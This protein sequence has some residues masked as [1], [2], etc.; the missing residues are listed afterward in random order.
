MSSTPHPD[1]RHLAAYATGN[2]AVDEAYSIAEHLGSCSEC[3]ATIQSL[4]AK[5]DTLVNALQTKPAAEPYDDEAELR[6]AVAKAAQ[7]SSLR[8]NE[9]AAAPAN[10]T[11]AQAATKTPPKLGPYQLLAK[12]GEGGMGAVFKARHEHLDKIV[13][14]KVLSKKALQDSAAVARFRRE[15]KAVGAL[16]HPNIVGAHDAGEQQGVHFLVMEYVAGRD[17]STLVKQNGPVTVAQAISYMQQAAKG[18]AFAH[19][20]NIV[21]RDIKPANLLVDGE[22]TIKILDLGLARL[23]DGGATGAAANVEANQGLT[24]TGQVMGTVDYMA[25][26]QAFDTHRA[27]AKADVYSLGC[28]LFRIL[29]GKNAYGGDTV[30]Q[31]ILAHREHPIPSLIERRPE[32]PAALDAIYR[33]MMTKQPEQRPTMAELCMEF[34]ALANPA[35]AQSGPM[36]VIDTAKK[37]VGVK[38]Q[39]SATNQL[40]AEPRTKRHANSAGGGRGF[41]PPKKLIAACGGFAILFAGVIFTIRD[42]DGNKV[43]EVHAPDGSSVEA[44]PSSKPAGAIRPAITLAPVAGAGAPL[45]PGDYA[46]RFSHGASV[47]V[48]SLAEALDPAGPLTVECWLTPGYYLYGQ[49]EQLGSTLVKY[50][51]EVPY[52]GFGGAPF[53]TAIN[54]SGNFDF[55]LYANELLT[56]EGDEGKPP[57]VLAAQGQ[58]GAN[59]IYIGGGG[60]SVAKQRPIHLACVRSRNKAQFYVAGK[61]HHFKDLPPITLAKAKQPFTI[62]GKDGNADRYFHGVINEVRVSKTVRYDKDFTPPTRFEPDPETTALYHFDEATGDV[63]HDASANKHDGKIVGAKWVRADGSEIPPPSAPAATPTG[64]AGTIAPI[65]PASPIPAA[66]SSTGYALSFGEG[67]TVEIP[68]LNDAFDPTGPLTVE[69]WI[70]PRFYNAQKKQ[71]DSPLTQFRGAVPIMAFYLQTEDYVKESGH[72]TGTQYELIPKFENGAHKAPFVGANG[73]SSRRWHLAAVRSDRKLL[74]FTDGKLRQEKELPAV[75]MRLAQ[76]SFTLGGQHD[77]DDS[78]FHGWISEVRISQ[79]ARYQQDF[80]PATVLADEPDTIALYHFDEGSGTILHDASGHGHDGK[81]VGATWVTLDGRPVAAEPTTKG[82]TP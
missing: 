14:I 66:A 31:K 61:L 8:A 82:P 7:V 40:A 74:F 62:G 21:H 23:D 30:V 64:P 20:K 38:A 71:D 35:A 1:E 53:Y 55:R 78:Y 36:I 25:P 59:R 9:P 28:T 54:N 69:C 24:Q 70:T 79:A 12:L 76:N 29:T 33:R 27:D 65:S 43:A 18:L 16:H 22:E 50:E 46:L 81:I 52:L 26:E 19:G 68:S 77:K 6:Q 2:L 39:D 34:E 11:A 41:K 3:E 47:E 4:E 42:R 49:P 51:G 75:R 57:L 58:R 60:S 56:G 37:G 32:V 44:V 15:M 5:S 73:E 17:L 13:A 10:S 67:S 80:K 63:L 72:S 48:P 45:P